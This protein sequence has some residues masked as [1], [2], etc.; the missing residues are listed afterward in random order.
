MNDDKDVLFRRIEAYCSHIERL[1]FTLPPPDS[2][3]TELVS[4]AIAVRS[5]AYELYD[6]VPTISNG[7]THAP[8]FLPTS[9]SIDPHKA[10]E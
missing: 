8:M 3:C 6:L 1:A 10:G 7:E 4:A 2:R 5:L 9:K